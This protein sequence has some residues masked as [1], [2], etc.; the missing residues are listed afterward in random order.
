MAIWTGTDGVY[1]VAANWSPANVPDD[2]AEIAQFTNNGAATTVTISG[3]NALLGGITFDANAP[4]YSISLAAAGTAISFFGAGITNNSSVAQNL[5]T[6]TGNTIQF[7]SSSS[8]GNATITITSGTFVQF[9]NTSSGGSARLIV[10]GGYLVL[11]TSSGAV[12]IGSLEGSGLVFGSTDS[13]GAGNQILTVGNLNTDT[14]FSGVL[15]SHIINNPSFFGLTKVGTGTLT[16]SGSAGAMYTLATTVSAGTL[17]AGV[18]NVFSDDSAY[19]VSNLATLDLNGFNQT[20]GSLGGGATASVKLGAATL[21]AGRNNGTT[22]FSGAISGTGGLVK[23]GTGA[24]TLS[25]TN[26]YSGATSVT[27]GTLA[28]GGFN[29]ISDNSAVSLTSSAMLRILDMETIGSLAGSGTVQILDTLTVG[30]ANNSVSFSGTI[31]DFGALTKV[32][33]GTQTLSGTN[34]YTGATTI[35]GGTLKVDGSITSAVTVNSGATLA[36]DGSVGSVTVNSGGHV[37]PG[38]SPGSLATGN[39]TLNVGSSYDVEIAGTAPGT[40]Y[41]QIIVT[42]TVTLAGGLTVT[43]LNGFTPTDGSSFTIIDN[44]GSDAVSGTFAGLGEGAFF[45]VEGAH[46]AI[47]YS[48]GT[49]NDVVVTSIN[50][51][52]TAADSTVGTLED[53]TYVFAT[54]DFGFADLLDGNSLKA[55]T[56]VTVP[57]TGRL[58]LNGAAL[59]AGT[60]VDVADII[61]GRLT[62]VPA[63]NASGSPSGSFTFRVQDNGGTAYGGSDTSTAA[64]TMTLN[65]TAVNDAPT[66]ALTPVVTTLDETADISTA[67]KVADIVVNDIDGGANALALTGADAGLFEIQGNALVLRAGA[68]LDFE[69]NPMLDVTVSLDDGDGAGPDG[70]ASL[71]IAIADVAEVI[72]GTNKKNVLSGSAASEIILGKS[73]NDTIRGHGGDD[74][75][76]GGR[77]ADKMNGGDGADSF[78]FL[79]GD[80]PKP[81]AADKW[82]SPLNGKFDYISDFQPGVDVI[83]LSA[84]DANTKKAGNQ[85]FH[86]EGKGKLSDSRGE[87]VYEFYGTKASARYTIISGDTNGD[88]NFDFRIVLKGHHHLDTSDFIL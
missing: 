84:I 50:D 16:L 47:T 53:T 11:Q 41:D 62:Y 55:V 9:F 83:D 68:V 48:G 18:A 40:Q 61:A 64:Y 34:T 58:E 73:G 14:T 74:T 52:P 23:E 6:G 43:L 66:L 63:S 82:L 88:G 38:S 33:T 30:A 8:A 81:R 29:A 51:A 19:S 4:T 49:G 32:G 25:G 45:T 17:K 3:V 54:A 2:G 65:V 75:I 26:T 5:S 85:A 24:L 39:F 46:Y 79:P 10:D 21:T 67:R 1:N 72:T 57:A 7:A 35:N 12:S 15:G 22:G 59:A 69:T 77:G 42:G 37:G 71:S 31:N 13:G 78:V 76:V 27:G 60:I 86:F 20:I 70:S 56:I 80:L 28:L 44:D 36:G 87:L